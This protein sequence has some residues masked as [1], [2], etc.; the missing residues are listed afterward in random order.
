MALTAGIV[1]LPNVGKSTLFNAI[2]NSQVLAE[3]YPF[4]TISPNV[5]V[6]EV[7]DERMD[8]IVKLFDPKKTIYTTFEFTDIAGLVKG[9]SKGEGLGNQFLANIRQT[10]AIVHVVRCF[11]DANIEHVEGTV[12]PVRDIEEIN[13]ELCL[14]DLDTVENRIAKVARKAQTKEKDAVAEYDTL[15][16]LK[17]ALEAGTPVR[18]AE[19]GDKDRE[20]IRNYSLLTNKPVIYVANMSDEEISAPEENAYYRAVKAFADEE[21]SECIAVCAKIEE[22]LS[23]MEKEEKQMF[24]DDLGIRTAGLDQ[25]IQAAYH[26]LGLR[27]FFTVGKPECRAWTF[28]EGMLAPQCAGIIHTD[29]ERG[30]IRAEIYSYDDLMEYKTEASLR[31]HGKIRLEGKE[32]AMKDGDIVFFRFNV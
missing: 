2:T 9:A 1:G 11:D 16:K 28:K 7:P 23:G 25:I 27:T 10:D 24:L 30:F 13:L 31:E 32:Y 8:E 26:L 19:L 18:L 3:N 29:F 21:G 6:V 20:I 17:P 5:G 14:A 15:M 4:A 12:D 22:E